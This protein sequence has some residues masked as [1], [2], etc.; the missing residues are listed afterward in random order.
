MSCSFRSIVWHKRENMCYL[1]F[2]TW[3]VSLNMI[4]SSS[5]CFPEK[6]FILQLK[7]TPLCLWT[8]LSLLIYQF[9]DTSADNLSIRTLSIWIFSLLW[10]IHTCPCMNQNI[11]FY[12]CIRFHS[13]N[14]LPIPFTYWWSLEIFQL[15]IFLNKASRKLVSPVITCDCPRFTIRTMYYQ[16][17]T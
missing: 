4:I 9:W 15:E 12:C 10:E 13:V 16:R 3:L 7:N 6:N 1:S 2:W 8:T 17:K 14:V 5:I 11:A